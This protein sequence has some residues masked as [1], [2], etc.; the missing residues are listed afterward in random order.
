MRLTT[1]SDYALRVLMYLAVAPEKRATVREIADA[2][3]IS[4][5]HLAK[6][7]Q[8]LVKAEMVQSASGR[9]G[10]LRLNVEPRALTLG[11]IVRAAEDDLA[12]VECLG[13]TRF[14]RVAGVCGA[15]E[16]FSTALDSFFAELDSHTLATVLRNREGIRGALSVVSRAA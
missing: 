3:H 12:I 1:H 10:G 5:N 4:Q 11:A 6:V 16:I 14:C 8:R 2:F 13:H 7:A 9:Y 15:R